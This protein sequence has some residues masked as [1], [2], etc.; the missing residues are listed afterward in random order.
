MVGNG[1]AF[2]Q[3]ILRAAAFAGSEAPVLLTGET[4]T[5]KELCARV[6]HLMSKRQHGPFIPVECGAVPEHLF[7]NE[8]FGHARGAFTDAHADQKGLVALAHG[9]TLFLDEVDAL[10]TSLQAKILR[11]LQE[12][13][14]RPLGC[15]QFRNSNVR[16]IAATNSNLERLVREKR[17]REDLFFRLN[18]LRVHLPALRQRPEDI[19]LLARHFVEEICSTADLP[20]KVLS[21][22]SIRKL[23][24]HHWPGNVRELYN[25]LHRAVVCTPG[26]Q[27][28]SAQID[29][30]CF[31]V[32]AEASRV[33]FRGAKLQ[34]IQNFER[35]YVRNLLEEYDGNITRAARA[36]GKDRRAFGRLA[37]KYGFPQRSS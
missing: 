20:K 11:L 27:I 29:F 34:A 35:E 37:K 8:V 32:P 12:R 15:E 22:A 5:G 21:P 14:Y 28:A 6:V 19:A 7:E 31:D 18:V 10:S 24:T 9:G 33:S 3:V 1:A 26:T 2:Q 25:T 4:G 23:E 16:T 17:F 30:C 13:T 36:A